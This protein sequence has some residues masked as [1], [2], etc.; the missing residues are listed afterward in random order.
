MMAPPAGRRRPPT[1]AESPLSFISRAH[2]QASGDFTG[3][4]LRKTSSSGSLGLCEQH[5][6]L[7]P[8]T[9]VKSHWPGDA[10][11]LLSSFPVIPEAQPQGQASVPASTP[12]RLFGFS[13]SE[14]DDFASHSDLLASSLFPDVPFN[15]ALV[16]NS[17]NMKVEGCTTSVAGGSA[18]ANPPHS[19]NDSG[20]FPGDASL[21]LDDSGQAADFDEFDDDGS[22][23]FDNDAELDPETAAK[24]KVVQKAQEE[25]SAVGA[26]GEFACPYCD[27]S[28]NGKHAR[29]IWRRHL[30]DKHAIPLS[31]QPRRTRWDG[32]ANRP[33]N[34]EER[35][36]RMLESKRKWARK[37]RLMEK[38][39]QEG[40]PA[41][42]AAR[43]AMHHQHRW[44]PER[45]LFAAHNH[46]YA[47]PMMAHQERLYAS[48]PPSRSEHPGYH[49]ATPIGQP[50]S[51]SH[52]PL[53]LQSLYSNA[54]P[55]DAAVFHSHHPAAPHYVHPPNPHG[56]ELP[57]PGTVDRIFGVPQ[58]ERSAARQGT[59][60]SSSRQSMTLLT[61][62]APIFPPHE[63]IPAHRD[64]RHSKDLPQASP[65]RI[66][67]LRANAGHLGELSSRAGPSLVTSPGRVVPGPF[68]G[69][70]QL[71]FPSGTAGHRQRPGEDRL[72]D[73]YSDAQRTSPES[74]KSED[75]DKLLHRQQR[76]SSASQAD[77]G[78]SDPLTPPDSHS[79]AAHGGAGLAYSIA[80]NAKGQPPAADSLPASS[81]PRH[82]AR[83]AAWKPHTGAHNPFSL[84]SHKISPAI[85]RTQS[86]SMSRSASDT[87]ASPT[88]ARRT[89]ERGGAS[90]LIPPLGS[91]TT[92]AAMASP[93]ARERT[94]PPL[95]GT[96]RRSNGLKSSHDED[97]PLLTMSFEGPS[98]LD[99]LRRPGRQQG[100]LMTPLDYESREA[101]TKRTPFKFSSK[102]AGRSS[103]LFQVPQTIGRPTPARRVGQQSDQF[104]SP[105]HLDLTES[106][107]LAPHSI[108]RPSGST[109]YG[110]FGNTGAITPLEGPTPVRHLGALAASP[111]HPSPSS[112]LRAIRPDNLPSSAV[113]TAQPEAER[114]EDE[115]EEE[116]EPGRFAMQE[117]P[118]RPSASQ[119]SASSRSLG[120]GSSQ[121][122][123]TSKTTTVLNLPPPIRPLSYRSGGSVDPSQG[124]TPSPT[125]ADTR[126]SAMQD[127]SITDE[128][129][130]RDQEKAMPETQKQTEGSERD[131]RSALRSPPSS[132][133]RP[134]LNSRML[135]ES[136]LA[137]RKRERSP[138]TP[139]HQHNLEATGSRSSAASPSSRKAVRL[140]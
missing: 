139:R 49:G 39:G 76:S 31:Q 83:N 116:D 28:Y 53:P 26:T 64:S 94:L 47:E 72:A 115:E 130:R 24:L 129:R 55:P 136:P 125:A 90:V 62:G 18:D 38:H 98:L 74:F 3:T 51:I 114:V 48:L 4:P 66:S 87:L 96:P 108:L 99:S 134:L 101:G 43:A 52:P 119:R 137:S 113:R 59:S 123:S 2:R 133:I 16:V 89:T 40:T 50:F 56:L 78:K 44:E 84:E 110:H 42:A 5:R 112:P 106:L 120:L 97:A 77:G 132:P 75:E 80:N 11:D 45:P 36:Q 65:T 128:Q 8:R 102:D 34:A 57:S 105:Q 20:Y 81:T 15:H 79:L 14:I 103:S 17:I 109:S 41:Q 127:L 58:Y 111:W 29:S 63:D 12:G 27:K 126:V 61:A 22:P 54:A 68:A 85:A 10:A 88:S 32:D 107:G 6:P 138:S 121:N 19:A 82:S 93:M 13:Q 135:Y 92:D 100:S 73:P 69:H 35:R 118:S 1:A 86:T 71:G 117:T 104:S 37:K 7:T 60:Q 21:D 140:V 131:L 91:G 30:Q 46:G 124:I 25:A 33:K 70:R 95:I 23:L 67:H 9:G 122:G